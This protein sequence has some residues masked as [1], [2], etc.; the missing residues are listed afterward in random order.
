MEIEQNGVDSMSRENSELRAQ[1]DNIKE[2]FSSKVSELEERIELLI[3]EIELAR[4][5]CDILSERLDDIFSLILFVSKMGKN[6]LMVFV[7]AVLNY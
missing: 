5:G 3:T 1:L 4:H 2:A 6:L 7:N